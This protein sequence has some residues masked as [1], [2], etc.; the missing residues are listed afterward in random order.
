MKCSDA[1]AEG[2]TWRPEFTFLGLLVWGTVKEAVFS[3]VE[4]HHTSEEAAKIT[5]DQFHMENTFLSKVV[6]FKLMTA[7]SVR[8][9]FFKN[10]KF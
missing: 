2:S 10:G 1:V 5:F 3:E 7:I 9:L 4:H 8:M 6:F